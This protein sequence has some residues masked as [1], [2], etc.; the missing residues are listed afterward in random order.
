MKKLLATLFVIL[1]ALCLFSCKPTTFTVTFDANGGSEVEAQAVEECKNATKPENPTKE[2]Y[3]FLGWFN[4]NAEFKFDSSIEGDI[5][6][7]AKWEKKTYTVTFD[8]NGGNGDTTKTVEH[9]AT[10]K[11]PMASKP[12]HTLLGWYNGDTKWDFKTDTVTEDIT[13]TARWEAFN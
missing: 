5:T 11:A 2:G 12:K 1:F 6:L 3:N 7:K 9:G 13:L 8:T 10:V 4:G